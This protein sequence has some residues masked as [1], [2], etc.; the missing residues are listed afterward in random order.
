MRDVITLERLGE[1]LLQKK[2]MIHPIFLDTEFDQNY[3]FVS[4][5]FIG[6][7]VDKLSIGRIGK[8]ATKKAAKKVAK[9]AA[10]KK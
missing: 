1:S 3:T 6:C 10:K 2:F 5:N 4:C 8:M 9:K 7:S